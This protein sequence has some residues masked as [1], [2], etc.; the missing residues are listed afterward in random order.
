MDVVCYESL[1]R[2]IDETDY[3]IIAC[4]I[5]KQYSKRN[6]INGDCF[7]SDTSLE[8]RLKKLYKRLRVNS[9]AEL[10]LKLVKMSQ[11]VDITKLKCG[12]ISNCKAKE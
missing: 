3:S 8:Y 7:L 9:Y 12:I 5:E 1:F 2:S 11:N 6:M 10:Y 4:I